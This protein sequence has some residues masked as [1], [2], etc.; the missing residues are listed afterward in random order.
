MKLS[1]EERKKWSQNLHQK[2]EDKQ[3]EFKKK[4]TAEVKDQKRDPK[5]L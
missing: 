1:W 3:N 4:K 2:L 5:N